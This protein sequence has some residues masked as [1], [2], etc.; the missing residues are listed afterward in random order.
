MSIALN[1]A[2]RTVSGVFESM[3]GDV[4]SIKKSDACQCCADF[5]ENT[6]KVSF[7]RTQDRDN[8]NG[9]NAR[10]QAVLDGRG[11]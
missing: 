4:A 11:T 8:A 5:G 9:E 10:D 1:A 7:D 3:V 2:N 6:D